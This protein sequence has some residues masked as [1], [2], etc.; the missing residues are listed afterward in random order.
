MKQYIL[1]ILVFLVIAG[2]VS[3]STVSL[4][5]PGV[6]ENIA[7]AIRSG[8]SKSLAIYFSSTVEITIP[9]KEGTFS[10]VQAEMVM[11][12]FFSKIPPSSF[13]LDQ[14]G[15]SVGGSQ[16]IIGTYKSN[17]QV[18]KAYILLKPIEGSMLIQQIQFEAD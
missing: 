13:V 4:I 15:N 10:K 17:N 9:G 16:F 2:M 7:S 8:N 14:K 12:D 3:G 11:K 5:V 6:H 1:Q 18:Y